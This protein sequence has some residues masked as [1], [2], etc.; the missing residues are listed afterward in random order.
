MEAYW[1]TCNKVF[2]FLSDCFLYRNIVKKLLEKAISP[3]IK[4]CETIWEIGYPDFGFGKYPHY[5]EKP[6]LLKSEDN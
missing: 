4:D 2:S 6:L 5:C 1:K 3:L